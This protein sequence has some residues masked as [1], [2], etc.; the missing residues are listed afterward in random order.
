MRSGRNDEEGFTGLEAAIVLI[1]FVVV[2]AVFSYVMLGAGFFTSQKSQEVVHSSVEQAS[3]S[4]EIRGEVLGR[5]VSTTNAIDTI[6]FVIAQTAGGSA[7]DM[8]AVIMTYSTS[9]GVE[10]LNHADGDA[11]ASS[12]PSAYTLGAK[13]W[14]VYQ[15]LG[16]DADNLIEKGEQFIIRAQPTAALSANEKFSLE[17]KPAEGA[18]LGLKRTVPPQIDA[19]N[20]LY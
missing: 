2:A 16:G 9:K 11:T 8:D 18:A 4:L 14:I 1:A 15:K 13:E 17:I 20:K 10:T 3:A 7:V 19:V 12:N 6:E 5:A